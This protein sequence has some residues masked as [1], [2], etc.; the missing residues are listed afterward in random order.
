LI[1]LS[2]PVLIIA[3]GVSLGAQLARGQRHVADTPL[4]ILKARYARGEITQQQF[5]EMKRNLADP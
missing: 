1:M 4:D 3:L 5:E 2:I